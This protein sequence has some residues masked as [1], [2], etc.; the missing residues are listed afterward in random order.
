MMRVAIVDDE[1]LARLAVKAR[2]AR[3]A[4]LELV[5]EYGDGDTARPSLARHDP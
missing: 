5:A 1:P 3:H 4:D 2:L